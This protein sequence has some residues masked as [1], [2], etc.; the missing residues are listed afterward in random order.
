MGLKVPDDY[1]VVG[2]IAKYISDEFHLP[3]VSI[4]T[5]V[6]MLAETVIHALVTKIETPEQRLSDQLMT[7]PLAVPFAG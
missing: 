3:F 2:V 7:F 5:Y 6:N 4:D 1:Y